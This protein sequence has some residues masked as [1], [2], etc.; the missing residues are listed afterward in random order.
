MPT[1]SPARTASETSLTATAPASSRAQI[2]LSSSRLSPAA[3]LRARLHGQFLCAD[4]GARHGVRREVSDSAVAG[5]FAAPQDG[6]FI[7]E[8]HHLAEFVG[9]HQDG[10]IAALDHR[11]QQ[12][13]HLVGLAGGENRGRL[14]KDE[15][16]SLEIE[17]LEDLAFLPFAGGNIGH[18]G[19]KRHL[20]RHAI[21][22]GL[23]LLS[24]FFPVDDGGHIVAR[25][26]EIFG[27]RHRRH[28]REMLVDHAETERVGI[29]R[30]CDRLFSAA[31]KNGAFRRSIIAHDAFDQRALAGAVLSEQGMER[32]GSNLQL[33]LI[34]GGKITKSHGHGD[35]INP[36][37]STW[38]RRLAD[39]HDK[40]PISA[41]EVATAPNT[42]P[43]ILIILRAWS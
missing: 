33:D 6:H 11:A 19:T 12:A 18:P 23:Q 15:K 28:Q 40:A 4:H 38:Q 10:Q 7:R 13:K 34:E 20:E 26:H 35:R 32:A 41:I 24:F 9:D 42:P 17:L 37:R 1:I 22:K 2:L 8:R 29:L 3:P 31:D 25:Q 5:K 14:V 39:D 16:T 27:D 21:E 30:I 43:C 36:E